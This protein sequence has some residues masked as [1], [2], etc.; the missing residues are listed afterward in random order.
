ME[1]RPPNRALRLSCDGPLRP[2]G[3]PLIARRAP[4]YVGRC[5]NQSVVTLDRPRI[6]D[7]R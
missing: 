5:S 7:V 2:E 6:C 4:K 3:Q 1:Y